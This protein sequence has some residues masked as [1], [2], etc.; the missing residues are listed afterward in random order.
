MDEDAAALGC[1]GVIFVIVSLTLSIWSFV[2]IGHIEK[3]MVRVQD[4]LI[5]F[6]PDK[7]IK[8]CPT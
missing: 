3:Q 1:L 5:G 4:Q 7:V 6:V 8:K 2:K